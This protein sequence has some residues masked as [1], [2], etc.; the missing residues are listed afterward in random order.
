M[1]QPVNDERLRQL[2]AELGQS[3]RSAI[4]S[5]ERVWAAALARTRAGRRRWGRWAVAAACVTAAAAAGL[6][7]RHRPT[8]PGLDAATELASWQSPT[9][10]LLRFPGDDLLRAVPMIETSHV[11]LEPLQ[12]AA[13]TP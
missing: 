13:P 8:I 3:D 6:I 11:R 10:S 5:F 1:N 2:I 7:L 9:A 12:P 4:P